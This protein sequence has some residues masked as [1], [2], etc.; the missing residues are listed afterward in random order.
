M[1]V[2]PGM[3]TLINTVRSYANAGPAEWT[4]ESDSAILTFWDDAEIQKVL[5]R[6]KA[7]YVHAPMEPITSYSAGSV[8]WKQYRTDVPNIESGADVF[9][10]EDTA[11]TVSGYTFDYSRG[12]ATF[13]AD[14][15]GKSLW[16]SGYAYD[17][18]A[19]AADMWR[20][21]ASHAA[22]MVD[23]STDG[24]SVKRSQTVRACLEMAA[25]YSSR[26]SS[27][28]VQTAKITRDDL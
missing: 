18:N 13:S 20:V 12:V 6:H 10:I 24:H 11:G 1:A 9:K 3:Q 8:V 2:R 28:G 21:K 23:W 25:Y 14:Q 26:S 22:E 15:A 4:I 27:E 16:W 5:D 7:E 19:A 17:L